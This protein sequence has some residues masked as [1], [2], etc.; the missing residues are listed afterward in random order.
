[1]LGAHTLHL[2]TDFGESVVLAALSF[3][4]GLSGRKFTDVSE[5]AIYRNFVVVAWLPIYVLIYWLPRWL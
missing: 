5:D 1:M 2:G 3:R 4:H